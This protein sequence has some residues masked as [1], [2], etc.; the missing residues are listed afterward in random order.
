MMRSFWQ[1]FGKVIHFGDVLSA[2]NIPISD[3]PTINRHVGNR[4]ENHLC[5]NHILGHCPHMVRGRCPFVH[6]IGT[7]LSDNFVGALCRLVTRDSIM[8]DGNGENNNNRGDSRGA[9]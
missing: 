2:G 5:S 6:V 8:N 7:D 9:M 3:L 4:G 1:R